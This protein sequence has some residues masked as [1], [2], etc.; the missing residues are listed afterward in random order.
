MRAIGRQ[1]LIKVTCSACSKFGCSAECEWIMMSDPVK[2]KDAS[3]DEI[4]QITM[5]ITRP[6]HMY[7]QDEFECFAE[8]V[9]KKRTQV[10]KIA[11]EVPKKKKRKTTGDRLIEL[12]LEEKLEKRGKNKENNNNNNSAELAD[13]AQLEETA[14]LIAAGNNPTISGCFKLRSKRGMHLQDSFQQLCGKTGVLTAIQKYFEAQLGS[15]AYKKMQARDVDPLVLIAMFSANSAEG[16]RINGGRAGSGDVRSECEEGL[17]AAIDKELKWM[18]M[19]I[20]GEKSIISECGDDFIERARKQRTLYNLM[21]DELSG[22]EEMLSW[23]T[24]TT[25]TSMD[26]EKRF[27]TVMDFFTCEGCFNRAGTR[28]AD[29]ILAL[30]CTNRMLSEVMNKER[31]SYEDMSLNVSPIKLGIYIE[32][33]Y[34]AGNG[35]G[36]GDGAGNWR[37]VDS[38]ERS[39]KETMRNLD[40]YSRG[41]M[42]RRQ[43]RYTELNPELFKNKEQQKDIADKDQKGKGSGKTSFAKGK[44]KGEYKGEY[45]SRLDKI[46]DYQKSQGGACMAVWEE[47]TKHL[48]EATK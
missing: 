32:G 3:S 46:C 10:S 6:E 27:T 4:S 22:P 26:T 48:D 12:M 11:E 33:M 42:E 7:M 19:Y 15:T 43:N 8:L 45:K 5:Q 40:E 41:L 44:G 17:R 13:S 1:D 34:K 47:T 16:I 18:R 9:N 21:I 30:N 35:S 37:D 29:G 25:L 28:T 38:F 24:L 31:K 2:K 20:T 39:H 36:K 23:K 14:K